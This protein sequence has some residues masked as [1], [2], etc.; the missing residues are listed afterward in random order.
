MIGMWR[1]G[2]SVVSSWRV[3]SRPD[4]FGSCTSIRMR[5]GS[6]LLREATPVSPSPASSRHT[7][8]T[9]EQLPH[10]LAVV[11]VVLDVEDRVLAHAARLA[12][13]R[14]GTENM[15]VEPLPEFAL[16]PDAAA[17][18]LHELLRDAEPEAGAAELAR[19]GGV[20]LTELREDVVE[21]LRRDADAGIG[22][23][24]DAACRR[25]RST[26]MSTLPCR[27]N[28]AHCRPGWSGTG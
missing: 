9:A 27:V 2:G 4:I 28:L 10:D 22:H 8:R 13:A 1:V 3:A 21:L 18:Q 26:A 25:R 16:D 6:V 5:S 12:P 17:E 24:V 15:K 7:G 11:L 20:D 23:A 19:D 14:N